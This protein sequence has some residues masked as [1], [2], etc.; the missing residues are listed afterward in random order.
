M[1][2]LIACN[3][4]VKDKKDASFSSSEIDNKSLTGM[5]DGKIFCIPSPYEFVFHIRSLK[6]PYNP[7]L[8]NPVGNSSLYESSFKKNINFGVYGID[9]AYISIYEQTSDAL[10][11]FSTLKSISQQIDLGEVFDVDVMERIENNM[12]TQDSLLIILTNTYKQADKTLKNE[13]QKNEAALIVA[14][15]WIE[16]LYILTQ[17]NKEK[18]NKII[19]K[20]IAEHKFSADNLL[21]L[22]RPYYDNSEEY[23][24]LIDGLVNICYQFDGVS[25]EYTYKKPITYPDLKKTLISSETQIAIYPEHLKNISEQ[26]VILRNKIIK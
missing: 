26:I 8:L 13:K 25:F 7:S 18:P 12:N 10:N 5:I 11:Y 14:G 19:E 20:R 23:K 15:S 17:I 22:L 6:I 9:L 2:S 24:Y 21:S 4:S 1:V 3:E 16:S